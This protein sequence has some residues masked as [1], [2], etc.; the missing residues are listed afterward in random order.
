MRLIESL[1]DEAELVAIESDWQQEIDRRVAEIDAGTVTARPA[2]A[3]F[4]A[5]RAALRQS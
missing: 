3:V 5:A 4:A 1:D 2:A